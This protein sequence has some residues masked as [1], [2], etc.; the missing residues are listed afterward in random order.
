MM[1]THFGRELAR[2]LTDFGFSPQGPGGIKGKIA[3]AIGVSREHFSR[4]TT[5]NS[6]EDIRTLPS[7]ERVPF[8]VSAV[9]DIAVRE[10]RISAEQY[11]HLEEELSLRLSTAIDQ[12][13]TEHGLVSGG[14]S[15]VYRCLLI[16]IC[17]GIFTPKELDRLVV[18]AKV[19]PSVF[20]EKFLQMLVLAREIRGLDPHPAVALL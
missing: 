14:G 12:D 15:P 16:M 19:S 17:E 10:G 11:G 8:I 5:R 1:Y 3:E 13:K 2:I 9:L 6:R 7:L 4:W 18:E 20:A